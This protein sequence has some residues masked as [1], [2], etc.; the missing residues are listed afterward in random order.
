[1][2]VTAH[3]QFLRLLLVHVTEAAQVL[4]GERQAGPTVRPP[5]DRRPSLAA[6]S[7]GTSRVFAAAVPLVT[8]AQ[9]GSVTTMACFANGGMT[10]LASGDEHGT[11]ALWRV[12]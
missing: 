2:R 7:V 5:G 6:G 8:H 11:V 9:V 4:C 3:D 12:L 10:Y 1:M